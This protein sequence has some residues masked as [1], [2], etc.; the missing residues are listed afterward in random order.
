MFYISQ[1]QKDDCG[2]TCLKM[3]LANINKDGNYLYLPQKVDHG[4]YSYSD[5]VDIAKDYGLFL[6][7]VRVTEKETVLRCSNFPFIATV[8]VI[9]G[10][11][12]AVLVTKVTKKKV[13]YLDPRRGTIKTKLKDFLKMWDST[14]LIIEHF[15]K[16]KCTV[17]IKDPISSTNKFL[18]G[19]TQMIA[20]VLAVFGVHFIKDDTPI[21]VPAIFLSLAIV[22]ELLMK[23]L[24]FRLMKKLDDYFFSEPV[25]PD[26]NFKEYIE[27]Y[28]R[29]KGVSLTSPLN[30]ILTF[31]FS[32]ALLIVVLLNDVRNILLVAIP[33]A[34]AIID[35]TF[36]SPKTKNKRDNINELEDDLDSADSKVDLRNRMRIIHD[37][38]YAYSYLKIAVSYLYVGIIILTTMLTMRICGISSFPYIIFYTCISVTLF[39]SLNQLFS[40]GEKIQEYNMVKI[41]LNNS[42]KR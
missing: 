5:I 23:A 9:N 33:L 25:L 27:R 14:C 38:A 32:L 40:F 15:E 16:R 36:V 18:L 17:G 37:K 41:R 19:F 3:M 34:L 30:Y 1:T 6:S 39:K 20:G 10:V 2:F 28:E 42:I 11:N 35:V 8:Q 24:S 13:T 21:F 22:M 7:A 29:Y 4:Y 31:V 12:H 26:N